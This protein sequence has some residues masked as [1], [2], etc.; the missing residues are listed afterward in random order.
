VQGRHLYAADDATADVVDLRTRRE[1]RA[2]ADP[3]VVWAMLAP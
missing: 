2:V 3:G 1:A